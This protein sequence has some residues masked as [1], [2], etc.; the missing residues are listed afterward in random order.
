MHHT[1][2]QHWQAARR[3]APSSGTGPEQRS[4]TVSSTWEKFVATTDGM[5]FWDWLKGLAPRPSVERY[6]TWL[7]ALGPLAW[8]LLH[9]SSS[10]PVH[11]LTLRIF[12][13]Q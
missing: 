6:G 10:M 12:F 9:H 4:Q 5:V 7:L 13:L 2:Q 8:L 11:S 3:R 1:L